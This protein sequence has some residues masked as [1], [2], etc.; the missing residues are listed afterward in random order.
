MLSEFVILIILL[1]G[2]LIISWYV[3]KIVFLE[4]D[5]R[6]LMNNKFWVF[7]FIIGF[8]YVIIC[9][10]GYYVSFNYD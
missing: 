4:N 6:F 8:F 5:G 2:M 10:S 7:I 1:I 9:L 3:M